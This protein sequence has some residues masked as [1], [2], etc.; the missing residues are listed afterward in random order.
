VQ[1]ERGGEAE[2]VQEGGHYLGVVFWGGVSWLVGLVGDG[3]G[4]REGEGEGKWGRR[5]GGGAGEERGRKGREK[6]DEP[7]GTKVLR[8]VSV[9]G[10]VV[11][12]GVMMVGVVSGIV[13]VVVCVVAGG[14]DGC[15]DVE[16]R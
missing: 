12:A 8:F 5:G 2:G 4:K 13:A 11:V 9:A 7:R 15:E 1:G 3:D 14:F 16:V 6:G 10:E